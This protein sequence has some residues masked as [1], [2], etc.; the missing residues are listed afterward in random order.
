MISVVQVRFA[1]PDVR[2]GLVT[3]VQFMTP[4]AVFLIDEQGFVELPETAIPVFILLLAGTLQQRSGSRSGFAVNPVQTMANHRFVLPVEGVDDAW[5]AVHVPAV[6]AGIGEQ[7]TGIV[8]QPVGAGTP[9]MTTR[10]LKMQHQPCPLECMPRRGAERP[11][12]VGRVVMV[13][14]GQRLPALSEVLD[15][16]K[17]VRP[18]LLMDYPLD[19][20]Q[21]PVEPLCIAGHVGQ[22]EKGFGAVHVAVGTAVG[23]FM[24]PVLRERLAH[25]AFLLA[26]E[27]RLYDLNGVGEQCLSA[28]AARH[29][30]RAGGQ[31]DECMQVGLLVGL[32]A[33]FKRGAEPA[34]VLG[35][36]QRA[37][38]CG[39]PVIDQRGA[40]GY[41]LRMG[42]GK[43]VSHAC[44]VHGFGRGADHQTSVV[45][46]TAK[47]VFQPGCLGEGQQAVAFKRQPLMMGWRAQPTA[48]SVIIIVH[49]AMPP[50]SIRL[51]RLYRRSFDR[52]HNARPVVRRQADTTCINVGFYT[53]KRKTTWFRSAARRDSSWLDAL[54][55]LAP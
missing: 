3:L 29:H 16:L 35:I 28:R 49:D 11:E 45:V 51:C 38:E 17:V 4:A 47:A 27:M 13:V 21:R 53:L 18:G 24:A 10:R 44:S 33:V 55:W 50:P 6:A 43:T 2:T 12:T 42:H 41:A 7:L 25:G 37:A 54:I 8:E 52:G 40:A 22:R 32:A 39:D 19:N 31:R 14:V 30:R 34:V 46:K 48:E 26:P 15:D 23:F 5:C 20:A 1:R 36:A 9:G